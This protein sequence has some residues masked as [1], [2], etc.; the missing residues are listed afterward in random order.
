MEIKFITIKAGILEI[1][2]HS[3]FQRYFKN[4][5]WLFFGRLINL[6]FAFIIGVMI[7]RYLGPDQFGVFNY[8]ISFVGLFGFIPGFGVGNIISRDLVKFPEKK[9]DF[10]GTA[11]ILNMLGA[12]LSIVIIFLITFFYLKHDY[13][14]SILI[15]VMST[16]YILQSFN[17]IDSYF[18][19]MVLSK[20][21]VILQIISLFVSSLFKLL[22]IFLQLDLQFFIYLFVFDAAF[23]AVGLLFTYKL[24]HHKIFDWHFDFNLAKQLF[25][26]S[27]PLMFSVLF[28]AIYSRIDQVM[29]KNMLNN[30]AVGQ[31]SVAVK[32]S[33]FWIFIPGI[34]SSSVIPAIIN[35]KKNDQQVYE[36]RY[37]KLYLLIFYLA[38]SISFFI[39]IFA[40]TIVSVLFGPDYL[41]AV[42]P[43]RI[44]VWSGVASAVGYLVSMYLIIE[45][46]TK[47]IFFNTF[48]SMLINVILNLVL[49]PI[50]GISGAAIA[51]LIS[52]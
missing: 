11:F 4:T 5:S 10:L 6:V 21:I 15:I 45:K 14:T 40:K 1:W 18:Q 50:Y 29:L 2:N 22:F 30:E 23:L 12:V 37:K 17:V 25:K 32:L 49:I 24:N 47:I 44:Y 27:W 38:L 3:G 28:F 51:T 34:I 36:N 7:A 16:T 46:H 20:K 9:N 39:F 52:Y 19:A 42:N 48:L 8:V 26:E 33:E 35:A 31:Y 43:L 13:F 41:E